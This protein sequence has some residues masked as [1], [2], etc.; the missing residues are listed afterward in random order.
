MA[1]QKISWQL[2]HPKYWFTWLG[3]GLFYI[4]VQLMPYRFLLFCGR[5]LGRLLLKLTKRR[6]RIAQRNLELCFPEKTDIERQEM[7]VKNFESTGMGFLESAMAWWWP[8]WRLQR[9][10]HIEG[11]EVAERHKGKGALV[12]CF[13]FTWLEIA[14]VGLS[15]KTPGDGVYSHNKNAVI[16]FLQRRGRQRIQSSQSIERA[17]VRGMI[18]SLRKGRRVFYLPDQDYGRDMSL[19]VPFFNIPTAVMAATSRLASMGKAVVAPVTH[20][21]LPNAKGYKITVHEPWENFPSDDLEADVLR[22]SRA[23]EDEIR[24]HPEHYLWVH[25]RFKTRPAGE[26]SLYS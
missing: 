6:R 12:L 4:F 17:D 5:A 24:K 9:L 15:F 18:R 11:L 26:K 8:R 2:F 22:M 1:K 19:F 14:S 3:M 13:H 10:M 7:L 21:R 16:E 25:R 23:I 20:E